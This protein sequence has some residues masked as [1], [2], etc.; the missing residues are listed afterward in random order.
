MVLASRY[1][2]RLCLGFISSRYL[3]LRPFSELSLPGLPRGDLSF[4]DISLS[5]SSF[6]R[7]FLTSS[8]VSVT[9]DTIT[10]WTAGKGVG[11]RFSI[12]LLRNSALL[13]EI[14]LQT[15]LARE[16]NLVYCSI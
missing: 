16:A 13:L 14:G 15:L 1:S 11:A 3:S 7:S 5:E 10:D 12:I 2:R 6:S 4:W 9:K 8:A